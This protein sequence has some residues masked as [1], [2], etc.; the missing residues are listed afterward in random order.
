[1]I[2]IAPCENE[3]RL[4]IGVDPLQAINARYRPIDARVVFHR[5]RSQRIQAP[6]SIA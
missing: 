1:M 6:R 2:A 4:T 3:I 5:A